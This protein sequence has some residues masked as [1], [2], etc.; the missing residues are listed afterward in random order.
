[1]KFIWGSSRIFIVEEI[2]PKRIQQAIEVVE[3]A[4]NGKIGFCFKSV[5]KIPLHGGFEINNKIERRQ[6]AI[7][8]EQN[9]DIVPWIRDEVKELKHKA[10]EFILFDSI[11]EKKMKSNYHKLH[12]ALVLLSNDGI[13]GSYTLIA[14]GKLKVSW[15]SEWQ[16]PVIVEIKQG[17]TYTYDEL[18][19]KTKSMIQEEYEMD[20]AFCG[21]IIESIELK[22]TGVINKPY[23]GNINRSS[24]ELNPRVLQHRGQQDVQIPKLKEVSKLLQGLEPKD[25]V[26]VIAYLMYL[27]ERWRKR[28]L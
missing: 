2:Q 1:M 14:T 9:K 22:G 5:P 24:G 17:F 23:V 13:I 18:A 3:S 16:K 6:R 8:A 21:R 7:I 25:M 12:K 27:K 15:F 4:I 11:T 20:Q 26:K 28:S 19:I 10:K